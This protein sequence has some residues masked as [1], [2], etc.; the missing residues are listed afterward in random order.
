MNQNKL[1][2]KSQITFLYFRDLKPAS[3]FL[4]EVMGFD[5]VDDQ[6][7]AK[8]YR[9]S[10]N[11]YLG[12]VDEQKGFHKA[13][14]KNAVLITIVVDDVSW[15]YDYLKSK[16]V[17]ILKELREVEDIGVRCFVL[18]APGQYALEVQ[19]F[20]EPGAIKIFH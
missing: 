20:L 6:G 1:R 9:I 14:E 17:K 7:W 16:G 2:A 4:R 12:I 19:Q 18:E 10:G 15:W 8:I 13:Q 11:A 3:E 5:L